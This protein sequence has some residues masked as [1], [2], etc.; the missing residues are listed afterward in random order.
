MKEYYTYYYL[1]TCLCSD[2]ENFCLASAHTFSRSLYVFL[3]WREGGG[4]KERKGEGGWREE[5]KKEGE[6]KRG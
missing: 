5:V 3:A 1:D 2:S 4:G 6:D